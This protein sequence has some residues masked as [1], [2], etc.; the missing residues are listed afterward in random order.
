MNSQRHQTVR[1]LLI[2]RNS[3]LPLPLKSVMVVG[4]GDAGKTT[5]VHQLLTDKFSPNQFLMTDGVSMKEW[6]PTPQM[7]FSLW[8]FGGQQRT[9][10][11]PRGV[12]AAN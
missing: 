12:A 3:T 11:Y 4:L 7:N 6:K 1:F 10:G 5:L 9:C 2:S 8:D